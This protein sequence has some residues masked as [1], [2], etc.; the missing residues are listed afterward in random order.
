MKLIFV[1][2]CLYLMRTYGRITC[3]AL[4]TSACG[5]IFICLLGIREVQQIF[6][7]IVRPT[8]ITLH[9]F[10]IEIPMI[11]INLLFSRNWTLSASKM[12]KCIFILLTMIVSKNFTT[13]KLFS[14]YLNIQIIIYIKYRGLSILLQDLISFFFKYLKHYTISCCVCCHNRQHRKQ[15]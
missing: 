5:T 8:Q 9:K 6:L 7:L 15:P 14:T 12:K 1:I 3:Y 11:H 2:F 4:H 13:L 10:G